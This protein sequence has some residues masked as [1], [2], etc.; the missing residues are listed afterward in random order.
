[1]QCKNKSS[2]QER[3]ENVDQNIYPRGSK[4][5]E[6]VSLSSGARINDEHGHILSSH[7]ATTTRPAL[8]P[9]EDLSK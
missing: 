1:M 9:L 5:K 8:A 2:Y 4:T 7:T 6:A 3:R